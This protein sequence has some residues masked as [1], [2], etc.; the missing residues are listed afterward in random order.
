MIEKAKKVGREREKKAKQEK[1]RLASTLK[2]AIVEA[3]EC[4][5]GNTMKMKET[6]FL[7]SLCS[8]LN[9]WQNLGNQ[10]TEERRTHRII[11]QSI[12]QLRRF[13]GIQFM[14]MMTI[15]VCAAV[16]DSVTLGVVCFLSMIQVRLVSNPT[17]RMLH[18]HLLS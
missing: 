5:R 12:H 7:E 4:N 16:K 10:Q 11:C 13:S 14:K 18:P 17:S 9:H 3:V 6:Q 15:I 2:E 1:E 8:L